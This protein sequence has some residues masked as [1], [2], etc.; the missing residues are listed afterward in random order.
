MSANL[1]RRLNKLE[2]THKRILR[3]AW[4]L[5]SL[6]DISSSQ[7]SRYQA[8]PA[9]VL[10]TK[11]WH[12]GTPYIL[13]LTGIGEHYPEAADLVH[14]SHPVKR[15][16]DERIHAAELWLP[17]SK[18]KQEDYLK[19]QQEKVE[20]K[21]SLRPASRQ[22]YQTTIRPTAQERKVKAERD[23]L[24]ARAR[25]FIQVKQEKFKRRAGRTEPFPIDETLEA[26]EA[27]RVHSYDKVIEAEAE[28]LGFEKYGEGANHYRHQTVMV[29]NSILDLRKRGV[30]EVVIWG[31]ALPNTL[32][33]IAFFEALLPKIVE[34]AKAKDR[35]EKNKKAREAAERARHR[36]EYL[37]RQRG[38]T[39]APVAIP[40]A[41]E[42]K[43]DDVLKALMPPNIYEAYKKAQKLDGKESRSQIGIP[44][45]QNPDELIND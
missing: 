12:C 31:E 41:S 10:S 30:C 20:R 6:R 16:M 33:E 40:T 3:C 35:E 7:K 4:C 39:L 24:E 1:T 28:A 5:Y 23:D 36:E 38:E 17:L 37:A 44:Y 2:D 34:E 21:T 45:I 42:D 43:A 9:G 18:S 29:K 14:N 19:D 32:D 15:L 11:C 25:M 26:L 27:G 13:R 8:Q 22:A